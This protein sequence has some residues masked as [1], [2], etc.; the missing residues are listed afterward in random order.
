MHREKLIIF[1]R[2]P[3]A[4][5]VKTRLAAEI[6]SEAALAAYCTLVSRLVGNV[7]RLAPVELRFTP[8][9]AERECGAWLQD[10]WE[11]RPQGPG[12]LGE[13]LTAAFDESFARG[14]RRVVI[15]GSDCP[16][17]SANDIRLAWNALKSHDLVLGPAS[18]GGY[19]LIGLCRPCR[20]LFE[21]IPWSTGAVL[22]GTLDRAR[23]ARL[24]VK[25]LR[26]LSDVD[27]A[28]DWKQF[29]NIR[30]PPAAA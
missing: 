11:C 17:L 12:G 8:D 16:Y 21:R 20:Q 1:L 30:T 25:L 7:S 23:M 22:R 19:W 3:R 6:G 2:A 13:K 24:E 27:T 15:I 18:D 28:A 9:S 29:Q 14:A 5:T 4:K 26:R 10:G